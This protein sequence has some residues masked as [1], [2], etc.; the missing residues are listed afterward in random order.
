VEIGML[1]K[2][3][4]QL[5]VPLRIKLVGKIH[6][7][8]Y[9]YE[10]FS[11][12]KRLRSYGENCGFYLPFIITVPECVELGNNVSIAPYVHMWS[13]AGIK[14]G[15]NVMIASHTAI[16]TLTHDYTQEKMR[17]TIVSKPIVIEDDVWIG[18]HAVILPGVTI[19][20]GAVVGA[21]SIVTRDVEPYS[22]V[23]GTPARHQKYRNINLDLITQF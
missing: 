3:L 20:R 23:V 2:L 7:Y 10:S 4:R 9:E 21:G 6:E 5:L 8:L 17:N 1:T 12:K 19:G 13:D 14:I 11:L 18:A 15:N 22:I 16:T